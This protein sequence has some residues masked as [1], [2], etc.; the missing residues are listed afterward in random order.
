MH[1]LNDAV[2]GPYLPVRVTRD[3]VV[4]RR[5]TKSY[6]PP[7]CRTSQYLRT[8]IPFSV[9]LWNNLANPVFDGV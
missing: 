6:A 2:P 7:H 8:F 5:Y 1:P 9:S 3:A 4:T